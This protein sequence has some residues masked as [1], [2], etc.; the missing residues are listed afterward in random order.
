MSSNS[1]IKP[2]E[3]ADGLPREGVSDLTTT[4]LS[5]Y[6][7]CLNALS[8]QGVRTISSQELASRFDLNSSQI[9]KDLAHFGELGIRGVGYDVERLREHIRSTLGLDKT[10]N[11]AIIGAGHLGMALADYNGFNSD[12]FRTVA[13]LDVDPRKVGLTSRSGLPVESL[14]QLD[15]IVRERSVDIA[16]IAVPAR[17]AQQCCDSL[18]ALRVSGILNFAPIRLREHP[19]MKIRN[20][21][22]R[23][24]L[25]TLSFHLAHRDAAP[26]EP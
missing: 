17:V 7:R 21:D 10:R 6:L 13:L 22:L 2:A 20:V 5:L 11:V 9:R 26:E 16:V 12:G 24:S 19:G 3:T 25:E 18:A 14:D 15:T 8:A 1:N 23:T 4:R